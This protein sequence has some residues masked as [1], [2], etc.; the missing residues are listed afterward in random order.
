MQ[1]H[2]VIFYV[3]MVLG[4]SFLF[5]V[6]TT[7]AA[8]PTQTKPWDYTDPGHLRHKRS[9]RFCFK[10]PLV[11]RYCSRQNSRNDST[12][13][14]S[15]AHIYICSAA[16]LS[17]MRRS[18]VLSHQKK[19]RKDNIHDNLQLRLVWCG[20]NCTL[21]QSQ[22]HQHPV[23]SQQSFSQL[24]LVQFTLTVPRSHI[25]N[26]GIRQQSHQVSQHNL[27]LVVK[28]STQTTCL[29]LPLAE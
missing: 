26:H 28:F 5:Q 19:S 18:S 20:D 1:R 7:G 25:C 24:T 22:R 16:L 2:V 13:R 29:N 27:S 11:S 6:S 15:K 10:L 9:F 12:N 21:Q 14:L 17:Q 23:E 4:P 8:I 3:S